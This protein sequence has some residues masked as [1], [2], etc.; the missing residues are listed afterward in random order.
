MEVGRKREQALGVDNL[1]PL[2]VF[3]HLSFSKNEAETTGKDKGY[4]IY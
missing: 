2:P 3:P 1:I 4:F